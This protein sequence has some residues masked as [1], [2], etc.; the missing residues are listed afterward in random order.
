MLFYNCFVLAG[1]LFR[2]SWKFYG[3][4]KDP[5]AP[6]RLINSTM[7]VTPTSGG[8]SFA[9]MLRMWEKDVDG[10][11]SSVDANEDGKTRALEEKE[12]CGD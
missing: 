7:S 1:T 11:V 8:R 12:E 4:S 9:D 2:W 5:M 6:N 10:F 3:T